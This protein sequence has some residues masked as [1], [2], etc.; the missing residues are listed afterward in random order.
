MR[1]RIDVPSPIAYNKTIAGAGRYRPGR[2][3]LFAAPGGL[4]RV[5]GGGRKDREVSKMKLS[6][7]E[8]FI[9]VAQAGSITAAAQQLHVAQPGLTKSL[10]ALERELGVQ[11]MYRSNTGVCLTEGDKR[12]LADAR[13]IVQMYHSW[14]ELASL[15]TLR[16]VNVYAHISL[17]GFLLPEVM[18]HFREKHPE[19][20]VNEYA[21][22]CPTQFLSASSETPSLI[23]N[24]DSS[25]ENT[26][27]H[28]PGICR[29][30][31]AKGAYGILTSAASPLARRPA[32]TYADLLKSYLVLP[33]LTLGAI[34]P[35]KLPTTPIQDFLPRMIGIV[36]RKRIV[37]V[38][39]V[40]SVVELVRRRPETYGIS[41]SPAHLRYYGIQ[42]GD[43]VHIPLREQGVEGELS[44]LYYARAAQA[45]PAFQ[46]L[47]NDITEAAGHFLSKCP[48]SN[49]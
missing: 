37:E 48:P 8:Y 21:D 9:A 39:S 38:E 6:A 11:L 25:A 41:F 33:N 29:R 45:H 44:L 24:I 5:R 47:I 19:I 2:P 46:E 16:Q 34:G 35:D 27:A 23:L 14:K 40:G 3:S 36:S 43:L 26:A 20:Q 7:L 13:Q 12:V 30:L 32:L 22:A 1:R 10:Q 49:G 28:A 18:F 31:L 42:A 4:W 15:N 17:A